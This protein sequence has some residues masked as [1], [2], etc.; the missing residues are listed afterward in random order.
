MLN[1]KSA[2][3]GNTATLPGVFYLGE[4]LGIEEFRSS[5]V[6]KSGVQ[7]FRSSGVRSSE[8]QKFR[9]QEFR[10]SEVRS[11]EFRSSE[12][13][14][15]GVQKSEVQESGVCLR[16]AARTEVQELQ[17]YA[18]GTLREQESVGAGLQISST[19]NENF[20]K[21]ARTEV[22]L[23]HATRT[24]VFLRHTGRIGV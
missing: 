1:L 7:K 6:Q 24:G 10:S 19:M 8:V 21:P 18:Y 3:G 23:R 2:W 9:S 14:E 4:Y 20:G 16:H 15:S 12:V 22:C 5:E 13:Q 11:Q 17:K